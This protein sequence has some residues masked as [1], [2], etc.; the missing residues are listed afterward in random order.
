MAAILIDAG[1][2]IA[3]LNVHDKH[4]VICRTTLRQQRQPLISTLPVITEAMY[5]LGKIDG[6]KNRPAL[7]ELLFRDLIVIEDIGQ[8][9]LRRMSELMH[10]Y[11]DNPMDFA[12]ASLVAV[13]ERLK[14]NQI[15]TVD[16]N[17]F[18]TYRLNGK[19]SFQIIG[20]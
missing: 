20:P 14:T 5:F 16:R 18:S 15:F 17:D 9:D 12:D 10:K 19:T 1:P 3:A 7:W 11:A 2:L 4:H 8:D 13:A 6:G